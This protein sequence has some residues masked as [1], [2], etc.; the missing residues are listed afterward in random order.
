LSRLAAPQEAE[1]VENCFDALCSAVLLD[2]NK[3]RFVAAEGVELMLLIIR[4][5]GHAKTAALRTLDFATTRCG[6]AAERLVD[7][8]GLGA[9]FSAFSGR[10]AEAARA[11]RG[12]DAA[13]AEEARAVSLLASLFQ[14]LPRGARR[15]RVA[16][17]F[18]EQEHEKVD[19]LIELWFKYAARVNAAEQ[20]IAEDGDGEDED[21]DDDD[22]AERRYA[23]RM[24]AGLYTLQ[25]LALILA[26]LWCV[27][28]G[29]LN[30]RAARA[31]ALG[32]GALPHVRAV[33]REYAA[34]LG[35]AEGD[36]TR[37]ALQRRLERL[38]KELY[39]EGEE[40]SDADDD[41]EDADADAAARAGAP[42]E[43]GGRASAPGAAG[44]EDAAMGDAEEADAAPAARGHGGGGG[45][46]GASRAPAE[47]MVD[48]EDDA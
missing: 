45:G 42:Q 43:E 2:A 26:Q 5:K 38:T 25:Q 24:E 48:E 41:D 3:A 47:G 8:S 46:G 17:K 28:H 29:G 19:R 21:D 31:L 13:D 39:A 36:D 33:L 20:A 12:D 34:S 1:F 18:V 22:D 30:A 35:D 32:G 6:A 16:A 27:G 7:A 9:L 10:S 23:A 15:D 4:N 44:G 14:L 37:E 11:R 40:R